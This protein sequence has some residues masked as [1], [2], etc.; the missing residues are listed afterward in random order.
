M[1]FILYSEINAASIG[2]NLGMPEYSYY[3]VLKGFQQA[4]RALGDIVVVQNPAVEVDPIFREKQS[5]GVSCVF[6]SFSPPNKTLTSLAC[7][8]ICVFAWEFSNIPYEAWDDE[9]RNDWRFAL[10]RIGA[11]ITLSAHTAQVV[12]VVM[13]EDYPACAIPVPVHDFAPAVCRDLL[14]L[15][16]RCLVV[17]CTVI[18]SRFYRV[19]AEGFS[20]N[21]P[22]ACFQ[23]RDWS[24]ER[25]ELQFK[26]GDEGAALMGGFYEPEPWGGA[27]SKIAE[28]WVLLPFTLIGPCKIGVELAA[29]GPNI[30]K[31][32]TIKVGEQML[33]LHLSNDFVNHEFIFDVEQP[34]NLIQFGG[35]DITV[36][37]GARD[38]RSMGI[39]LRRLWVERIGVAVSQPLPLPGAVPITLDGVVYT[40][41]LNP[42]DGRKNWVEMLTAFCFA[43]RHEASATLLLKMTHRSIGTFL[44]RF[45]HTLQ[46]IGS[47]KCR[48]I[49]LHGYL[50]DVAFQQ[51]IDVSTY[52]VN[53]SQCEGLC[54]PLMEFMNCG[55]PAIAPNHTAL[56]DYING[57]NAFVVESSVEPGVWPHDPRDL[58]RTLRYRLNWS[59]LVRAFE[60]SFQA[61]RTNPE[62][63]RQMSR[64]ARE[65]QKAFCSQG[66]VAQK[67]RVFFAHN[68][69]NIDI[70]NKSSCD[71]GCRV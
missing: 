30:G 9:P 12:K 8:T 40:S 51:L 46:R 35:L 56:H 22:A 65:T 38:L 60:E 26:L 62:K 17:N 68:N 57:N 45:H 31:G 42:G 55:I 4:L 67:L 36:L 58:F 70:K 49:I 33:P 10:A 63:Y 18:D 21:I 41:V 15:I 64:C 50:D 28:P 23:P 7:P 39:G 54:L 27:W 69:F 24:G 71:D 37:P 14:S 52:Y 6:L 32:A 1:L 66:A 25:V 44:E 48:V 20:A 3:F 16:S 34:I 59:S 13:G 2:S 43:F 11:A 5:A 47:I 19:D 61:A 29:Y 53:S